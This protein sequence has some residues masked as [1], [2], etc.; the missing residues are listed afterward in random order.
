MFWQF[1]T[2]VMLTE[3]VSYVNKRAGQYNTSIRRSHLQGS[4]KWSFGLEN[5]SF[6]FEKAIAL[7]EVALLRTILTGTLSEFPCLRRTSSD[8]VV[9]LPLD[10]VISK[11]YA[12]TYRR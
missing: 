7:M 1:N 4:V 11:L 12:Q 9:T 6:T 5:E 3:M 8:E 10:T 2:T